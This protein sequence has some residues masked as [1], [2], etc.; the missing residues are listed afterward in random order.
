M[1]WYWEWLLLS[2][3]YFCHIFH[4]CWKQHFIL[5]HGST[6]NT[7]DIISI[8]Q[9]VGK[10]SA[11]YAV[12]KYLSWPPCTILLPILT[13]LPTY[14][15]ICKFRMCAKF[16]HTSY[17]L[18]SFYFIFLY[19]WYYDTWY[20]YSYGSRTAPSILYQLAGLWMTWAPSTSQLHDISENRSP[21]LL[22]CL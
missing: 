22:Q 2:N 12:I 8:V 13:Y 20:E 3:S 7:F 14:L 15:L 6:K 18:H 10:L 19:T 5:L 17:G 4:L 1:T 21:G 16:C 11:V 9:K